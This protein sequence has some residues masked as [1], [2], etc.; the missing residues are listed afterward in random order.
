MAT[1][2]QGVTTVDKPNGIVPAFSKKN[3][4]QDI[5][6]RK[7]EEQNKR[8][9]PIPGEGLPRIAHFNADQSGCG[10]WRMIWPAEQLLIHNKAVVSTMY[11]MV[12]DPG[13]YRGIKAVKFQ[14]QC[15]E[16]QYSFVKHLRKLSNKMKD[17]F[18]E[19]FKLIWEVD[20]VV[21]PVEGIPDYNRCK[22]AFTN[23]QIQDTVKRIVH[24]CDEMTVVSSDMAD[25]YRYHLSYENISVIP[26]Y[27]PK[28]WAGR[29]YDRLST[30]LRFEKRKKSGKIRVG[31]A[32]SATHFDV[33]NKVNQ[34]DDFHHVVDEIIKRVDD[35]DFVFFGGFPVKL[36]EFVR[37]GKIKHV[38]WG[39]L[40]RYPEIL[41]GLELDIMIAPLLENDFSNAKSNIKFLEAGVVGLPCVCQD[42]PP[43]TISPWKFTSGED[44]FERINAITYDINS[45]MY[46]SDKAKSIV[47]DYWLDDHLD[48]ILL[49]YITPYGDSSRRSNKHFYRNN[50]NQFDVKTIPVYSV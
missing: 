30:M 34:M 13:F 32:G 20:D 47:D 11:Q 23:P 7:Q 9:I 4:I 36:T 42:L 1:F 17:D 26:N 2:R 22:E 15:T 18:G 43:Y 25:H 45:Y 14:R 44:M 12:G 21:C 39:N 35:Y 49:P 5:L 41:A 28:N 37:Q 38:P 31:Y 16:A 48:E 27:L 29:N 46:A 24:L 10:F 6:K 8:R 33:A 50:S 3:N 19:G 40:D